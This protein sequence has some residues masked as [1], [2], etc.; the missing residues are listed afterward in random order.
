MSDIAHADGAAAP[1][2]N[3]LSSNTIRREKLGN[4]SYP[5]FWRYGRD[6]G[7]PEPDVIINRVRYWRE[8][9]VDEWIA[10]RTAIAKARKNHSR[11]SA[12]Q[13]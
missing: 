6:L 10:T 12:E 4:C 3:L 11:R 2:G 9:T 13:L 7:F 1:K 5:T 8:S